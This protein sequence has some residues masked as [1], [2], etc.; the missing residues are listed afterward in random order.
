QNKDITALGAC[1]RTGEIEV[2]AERDGRIQ[3]VVKPTFDAWIE[4]WTPGDTL[5]AREVTGRQPHASWVQGGHPDAPQRPSIRF[6]HVARAVA[7][8]AHDFEVECL[9]YDRYAFR[10]G[11][12][13]ECAALG[14]DVEFVEHPQGG[15]KKGKPTEAMVDAA[16]AAGR[17]PEGLWMPG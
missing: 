7:E 13:P 9:A 17:E 8:Y 12:E 3:T 15:V 4:A 16:K 2:R 5:A 11:F 14:I 10:R 1:V 6:D